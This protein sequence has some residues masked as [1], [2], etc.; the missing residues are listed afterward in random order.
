M[1]FAPAGE[2][3]E[4]V[5]AAV[6]L[7]LLERLDGDLAVGGRGHGEHGVDRVLGLHQRG[8][9]A[10][11]EVLVLDEPVALADPLVFLGLVPGVALAFRHVGAE[12]DVLVVGLG[13]VARDVH[14]VGHGLA[15]DGLALAL[16]P[17]EHPAFRLR[18]LA[19]GIV[20]QRH[21]NHVLERLQVCLLGD[22]GHG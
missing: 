3:R 7:E 10:R 9:A 2:V 12:R 5:K 11:D 13:V 22:L 17:V 8:H 19:C 15:G 16:G 21:R 14:Q 18:E 6:L 4:V 1:V 20:L